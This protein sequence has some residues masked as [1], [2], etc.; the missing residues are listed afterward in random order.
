MRGNRLSFCYVKYKSEPVANR[1]YK[2][3][4]INKWYT[5]KKNE[6]F[7]IRSFFVLYAL[8]YIKYLQNN[9]IF[10]LFKSVNLSVNSFNRAKYNV[11][12]V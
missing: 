12:D 1:H 2:V 4:I 7:K 5:M 11:Y 6:F 9:E 8:E 10:I 3:R